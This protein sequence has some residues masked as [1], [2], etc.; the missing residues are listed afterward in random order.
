MKSIIT[1]STLILLVFSTTF[2]QENNQKDTINIAENPKNNMYILD[3]IQKFNLAKVFK[4]D[5]SDC[6]LQII[7]GYSVLSYRSRGKNVFESGKIHNPGFIVFE[8]DTLKTFTIIT[9]NRYAGSSSGRRIFIG[10][11]E[12]INSKPIV[13]LL[14]NRKQVENILASHHASSEELKELYTRSDNQNK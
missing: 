11:K 2:A 6:Y 10:L 13:Y 9:D 7:N 12:N 14:N 8:G 1:L 4:M 5:E 3:S